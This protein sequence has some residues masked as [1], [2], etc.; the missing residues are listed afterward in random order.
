MNKRSVILDLE[1][2][3]DQERFRALAAQADVVVS[4]EGMATWAARGIDLERLSTVLSASGLD[5]LLA[6]W[7]QRTL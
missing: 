5:R 1:Q 7:P 2:R 3:Q 6:L 4:T